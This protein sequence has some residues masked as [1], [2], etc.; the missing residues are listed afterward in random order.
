MLHETNGVP[1][2]V[3]S[4]L[5]LTPVTNQS[6]QNCGHGLMVSPSELVCGCSILLYTI[7]S[8]LTVGKELT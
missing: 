2:Q 1:G 8:A 3:A 7:F 6:Q 5:I 4:K